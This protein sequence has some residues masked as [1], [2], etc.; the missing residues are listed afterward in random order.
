MQRSG[1]RY[2]PVNVWLPIVS[3]ALSSKSPSESNHPKAS[4]PRI[5]KQKRR[6]N[7]GLTNPGLTLI[8]R[9][10]SSK[11]YKA[12][13]NLVNQNVVYVDKTLSTFYGF[14]LF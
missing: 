8:M 1:Q 5:F 6:Q 11:I 7:Q 10:R 4:N 2:F 3:N 14:S 12:R 13:F 9:S